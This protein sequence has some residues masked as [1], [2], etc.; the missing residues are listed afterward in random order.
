MKLKRKARSRFCQEKSN[1]PTTD[2]PTTDTP[3][4]DTPTLS[5]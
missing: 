1:K 2:T 5:R 3:T 4:T